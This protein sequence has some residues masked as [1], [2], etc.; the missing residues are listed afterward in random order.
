MQREKL[1]TKQLRDIDAYL[2]EQVD[3]KTKKLFEDLGE[4]GYK[5]CFWGSHPDLYNN[6]A[7]SWAKM[8]FSEA[9]DGDL[10]DDR[11]F[12]CIFAFYRN[13]LRVFSNGRLQLQVLDLK[14]EEVI[15][16]DEG[17]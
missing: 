17:S 12:C 10:L 6:S 4:K 16:F 15:N 5:C 7:K 1:D 14:T 11:F 2:I 3:K 9:E 8:N 13:L